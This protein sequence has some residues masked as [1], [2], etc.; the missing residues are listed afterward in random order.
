MASQELTLYSTPGCP[1]AQRVEIAFE[2]AGVHPK[3]Y[4][5]DLQNKPE[6]YLSKVNPAGKVPAMTY[7]GPNVPPE[8]PSPDSVKLAES[9]VMLQFVIDLYP[10]SNLY[11]KA[12]VDRARARLFIERTASVFTSLFA[13]MLRGGAADALVESLRNLQSLLPPG[14]GW[15]IGPEFS[16]ADAAVAPFV[17]RIELYLRNDLGK[18]PVGEGPKL[19]KRLFEGTEFA[20]LQQYWKDIAARPSFKATYDELISTMQAVLVAHAKAHLSRES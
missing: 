5:I 12:P 7:G 2:E 9:L 3:K 8:E 10:N 16:F 4:V 13:F 15:A 18:Y 1:F 6:W 11:P 19:H 17:G 14:G 20:R